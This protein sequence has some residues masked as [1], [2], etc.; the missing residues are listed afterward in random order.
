[1]AASLS[2]RFLQRGR[3]ILLLSLR[4]P[5]RTRLPKRHPTPTGAH[6]AAYRGATSP[7]AANHAAP[8]ARDLAPPART[9]APR[10][11]QVVV[12]HSRRSGDTP[13]PTARLASAMQALQTYHGSWPPGPFRRHARPERPQ[14]PP[15]AEAPSTGPQPA[16]YLSTRLVVPADDRAPIGPPPPA[17]CGQPPAPRPP[18]GARFFHT[19]SHA[20]FRDREQHRKAAPRAQAPPPPYFAVPKPSPPR[21][22]HAGSQVPRHPT[23][24]TR[25]S[26]FTRPSQCRP[27][28]NTSGSTTPHR[29]RRSHRS[30][31]RTRPTRRINRHP[32][33][34]R[35]RCRPPRIRGAAMRRSSAQPARLRHAGHARSTHQ[36]P[37]SSPAPA[38]N[39]RY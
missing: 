16:R 15:A 35:P 29:P 12:P 6:L 8:T 22:P 7:P 31:T 21:E 4:L 19:S 32:K 13:R 14:P 34:P 25:P 5:C 3:I 1:M 26:R 33:R 20:E 17:T 30:P 37:R 18:V 38:P 9:P 28:A 11:R 24:K 2:A 39:P 10:R 36:P 27:P 23:H